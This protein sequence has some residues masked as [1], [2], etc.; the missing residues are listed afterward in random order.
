MRIS[1]IY[2]N[3][4]RRDFRQ[5]KTCISSIRYWYPEIPIRLIKDLGAGDFDT[6]VVERSFRVDVLDT[7]KKTFGWGFGKFEPLFQ[8]TGECFLFMDADTVMTGP[9]LDRLAGIDADFVVDE[10]IQPPDKLISLYFDPESLKMLDPGYT[11]P[12]Y[13][14][15][16][17]QWAATAGMLSRSDFD[18]WIEWGESPSL[19]YPDVFK[20]ADQGVFNYILHKKSSAGEI[21]LARSPI[22]IWP[23]GNA[24]DHVD[25]M[26]IRERRV[27]EDRVIH[28]A[29]MKNLP[30]RLMPRKDI[31]DFFDREYYGRT[32]VAQ[33][34]LDRLSEGFD[35]AR[36]LPARVA[37][38]LFRK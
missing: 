13:S 4:Y 36:E 33:R 9:L 27:S 11:Y 37:R 35:F 29:G 8:N 18:P 28:W 19:R 22:M 10:E 26:A 21:R 5:A 23:E 20:Q 3:T 12:G 2:L 38:R 14:F 17:G 16:T 25:L 15:N 30:R 6:R 1:S 24:A 34:Y 7:G 32:G 31:I